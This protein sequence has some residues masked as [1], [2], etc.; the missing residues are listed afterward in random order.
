MESAGYEEKLTNNLVCA[1]QLLS[2]IHR[3]AYELTIAI[4]SY[5]N[6]MLAMQKQTIA[7]KLAS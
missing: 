2:K 6:S 7:I 5:N 3:Q 4:G 1:S